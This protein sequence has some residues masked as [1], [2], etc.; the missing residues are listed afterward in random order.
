MPDASRARV[1]NELHSSEQQHD[2]RQRHHISDSQEMAGR[3]MPARRSRDEY[4][5]NAEDDEGISIDGEEPR[6]SL[7]KRAR[8]DDEQN[9]EDEEPEDVDDKAS[10]VTSVDVKR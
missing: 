1:V 10:P 6:S 2:S 9:D 5:R 4:E 7:R 3:V 8:R